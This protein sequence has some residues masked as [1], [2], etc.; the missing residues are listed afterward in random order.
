MSRARA[1]G[2]FP[3]GRGTRQAQLHQDGDPE[4]GARAAGEQ[5][6]VGAELGLDSEC[7]VMCSVRMVTVFQS[8][9]PQQSG[10][11]SVTL[12]SACLSAALPVHERPGVQR[13]QLLPRPHQRPRPLPLSDLPQEEEALP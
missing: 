11:R 13:G 4:G 6:R 1:V 3:R 7:G 10:V 8:S 2:V 9:V 12:I 5:E